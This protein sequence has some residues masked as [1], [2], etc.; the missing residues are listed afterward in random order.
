MEVLGGNDC[1]NPIHVPEPFDRGVCKLD[2]SIGTKGFVKDK[3]EDPAIREVATVNTSPV[4][5][6]LEQSM[7]N[8]RSTGVCS[9][10]DAAV[11]R[12]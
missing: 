12:I 9:H 6:I 7:G 10:N 8:I 4:V 1:V 2:P 3:V 5:E 11:R